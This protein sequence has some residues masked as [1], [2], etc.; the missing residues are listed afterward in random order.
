M[1][2]NNEYN[3]HK[4]SDM[5]N[6]YQTIDNEL[7]LLNTKANVIR[8]RKKILNETILNFIDENNL[9]SNKFLINDDSFKVHESYTSSPITLELVRSVLEKY[10]DSSLV[11]RIIAEI[12]LKKNSSKKR[13]KSLKRKSLRKKR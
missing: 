13:V 12:Q 3:K 9:Q 10:I 6:Q 11:S 2:L 8:K 4:L 7:S 1:A 5:L